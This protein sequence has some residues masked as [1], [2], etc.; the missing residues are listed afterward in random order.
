MLCYNDSICQPI[1]ICEDV[2]I[3]LE[4]CHIWVKSHIM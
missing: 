1:K 4:L 2:E 3:F